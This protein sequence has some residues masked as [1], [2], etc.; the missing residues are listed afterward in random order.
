MPVS[1]GF[2]T[3]VRVPSQIAPLPVARQVKNDG[4]GGLRGG[5]NG[6]SAKAAAGS[7]AIPA[8]NTIASSVRN[9]RAIVVHLYSLSRLG[10]PVE[11]SA[12][13]T[14][15]AWSAPVLASLLPGPAGAVRSGVRTSARRAV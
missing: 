15:T 3:R 4:G 14:A 11:S 8:R 10:L 12:A 7:T 5:R 9:G 2:S 1:T 13:G 6:G